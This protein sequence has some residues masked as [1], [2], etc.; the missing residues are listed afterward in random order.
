M[1]DLN[2]WGK[3]LREDNAIARQ[4]ERMVKEGGMM[5]N[6]NAMEGRR[7][8]MAFFRNPRGP[9]DDL[10]RGK[11]GDYPG[12]YGLAGEY[13][14]NREF[15]NPWQW[16][17]VWEEMGIPAE[18]RKALEMDQARGMGGRVV[19]D[20]GVYPAAQGDAMQK[21]A[22]DCN[23]TLHLERIPL[24]HTCGNQSQEHEPVRTGSRRHNL[25]LATCASSKRRVP[26][27]DR[28]IH[29]RGAIVMITGSTQRIHQSHSIALSLPDGR[30]ASKQCRWRPTLSSRS[31]KL[32]GWPNLF[33]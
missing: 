21:E 31:S 26:S 15:A 25:I 19:R 13:Q 18:T 20:N 28:S 29:S 22:E 7:V 5:D 12:R 4:R 11:D 10:R 2:H 33:R 9:P 32:R 23:V 30:C 3:N 1:G 6:G 24:T 14:G 27:R 17:C 8:G 16:N